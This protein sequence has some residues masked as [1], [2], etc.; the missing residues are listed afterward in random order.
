MRASGSSAQATAKVASLAAALAAVLLVWALSFTPAARLLEAKVFDLFTTLASPRGSAPSIV[1]LAIDEPSLQELQLQWPFPRS[2]HAR[3]LQRLH[4]DGAAAVGFDVV[5]AEPSRPD[6]D[7]ALAQAI[8]DGGPVVLA[9]SREML[10]SANAAL[11]TEVQPLP[12]FLSAGA[13]AGDIGVQPDAD[14]VVRRRPAGAGTLAEQLARLAAPGAHDTSAEFIEYL[15]PRGTIDTR[16][17]Y[18]ALVPGLL[19]AGFF[20]GKIVLVG[21]SMRTA[22]ELRAAQADTFNSPFVL[23]DA[24]DKVFPGVEIQATLLA[25]RLAGGGLFAVSPAWTLALLLAFAVALGRTGPVSHPAL[26]VALTFAGATAVGGVSWWLFTRRWWLPPAMPVAAM[27]TAFAATGVLNFAAVRRRGLRVRSLFSHYVPPE[28]VAQLVERPELLHLG[29]EVREVTVMFTDLEGF[30]AISEQLSAE[31]T[32]QMLTAYFNAMTPIIHRWHGTVDK[33]IGDAVMAFWG[34][35]LPDPAHAEHAMRAALEMQ[36][37]MEPLQR[38]L[39]SRGL[40][41]VAMR[42]GLH[43]GPAVVG[44]IGSSIRFSYTAVGDTVNLAARLEGANKAF[45]TGVLLSETTAAALPADLAL[46]VLDSVVVKGRSQAVRV[47]TPSDD[48]PLC[49]HSAAAI[50]ALH[51]RRWDECEAHLLAVLQQHPDDPAARRL[52]ER[53]QAARARPDAGWSPALALDKL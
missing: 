25:N 9:S 3:L 41:P 7:Q 49:E 13:V 48:K 1:I 45:G 36:R 31:Q 38:D 11:W 53:V 44:N 15:G 30:T 17:Y 5:F 23:G 10:E 39:R 20:R 46:R 32:V 24:A 29:G 2:V 27:F 47:F 52:L 37:A 16:S 26:A 19:P 34:A 33:Y 43:T 4:A 51:A 22:A 18:Q 42:I 40:P 14:Y 50:E 28:V 35:P 8:A 12:Q 6:E 21:R